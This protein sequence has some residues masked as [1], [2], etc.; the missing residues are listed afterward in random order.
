MYL[1]A[2]CD[3]ERVDLEKTEQMLHSYETRHPEIR[4]SVD[5]FE[6]ADELLYMVREKNYMP[7]LMLMDIYMP[8]KL[9]IEAARELRDMGSQSRIIF[10]TTSRE[11]ALEAFR[12]DASQ[13]LVKP[14]LE[15]Q[16]FQ[17]MDKLLRV[18]EEERKKFLL[19]RTGGRIQRIPVG[20]IIYCEAQGKTQYMYLAGGMQHLLRVTLTEIYEMLSRYQEFARVGVAYIVNLEYVDS[21]NAQDICLNTGKKIHLPRGAY[22]VLKEQYFKF[23]CEGN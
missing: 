8:E 9:G 13:Y 21:L 1:I 5:C 14:I 3:D 16:L 23:Y 11:H 22:K 12:V 10:L 6:S 18:M 19:L 15:K 7:D 2:L 20:D 4:F 17:V